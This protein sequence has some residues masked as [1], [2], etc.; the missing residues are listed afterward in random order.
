MN[1]IVFELRKLKL[2]FTSLIPPLIFAACTSGTVGEE[3][4]HSSE[5]QIPAGAIIQ[6]YESIEGLQRASVKEG[7]MTRAEG[8]F[9][10]GMHHGAW[11]AY[12][13]SGKITSMTTYYLGER[14]GVELLFDN[15]G[16]VAS[17]AYYY[18]NQLDGEY[19]IYKRRNIIERRN[20]TNGSLHGLQKK[21][22]ADG[23]TMEESS[24]V[25]GKI[26]G[27]ARWYDSEGNLT[28]EYTYEMGAL[29]NN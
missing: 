1:F 19:L 23:T 7:G 3:T 4:A 24:Y 2:W 11:V 5:S 12:D 15:L 22:Y 18:K 8:D 25:N 28:I 14:Q 26:D 13:A 10:N 20:Y 21:Y 29:I 27:I 17:K 9:F 6:D 16:Y